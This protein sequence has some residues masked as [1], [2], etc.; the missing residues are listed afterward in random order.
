MAYF[1]TIKHEDGSD[2]ELYIGDEQHIRELKDQVKKL[3]SENV[4]MMN[5]CSAYAEHQEILETNATAHNIEM[6][7][8]RKHNADLKGQI[9]NQNQKSMD[10]TR[11]ILRFLKQ[12]SDLETEVANVQE[13]YRR[14]FLAS[15]AVAIEQPDGTTEIII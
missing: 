3:E 13:N 1:A 10:S 12:I 4:E 6:R 2:V 8:I 7:K 14:L 9:K 15:N 5:E 11:D